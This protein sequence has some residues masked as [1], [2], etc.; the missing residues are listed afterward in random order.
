MTDNNGKEL[1]LV[2]IVSIVAI[3]AI[4]VLVIHE[5]SISGYASKR[6][7]TVPGAVSLVMPDNNAV[8]VPLNQVFDWTAEVKT[9]DFVVLYIDDEPGFSSPIIQEFQLRKTMKSYEVPTGVL[10]P[11]TTYYWRVV[12]Y[13]VAGATNSPTYTFTTSP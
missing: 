8:N 12:A 5:A 13:N 10:S 11:A 2:S 6:I 1:Y 3:V 7:D 9:T 4:L